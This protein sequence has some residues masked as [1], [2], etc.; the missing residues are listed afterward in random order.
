MENRSR[1]AAAVRAIYFFFSSLPLTSNC[2]VHRAEE[3]FAA[4]KISSGARDFSLSR[5]YERRCEFRMYVCVWV[6]GGG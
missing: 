6:L 1:P 4:G 3:E 2:I 5:L